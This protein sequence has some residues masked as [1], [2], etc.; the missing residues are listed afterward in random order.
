MLSSSNAIPCGA[1][2]DAATAFEKGQRE[3]E[4]L[5]EEVINARL[6]LQ[7][8]KAPGPN[9]GR[10]C[11]RCLRAGD[12]LVQW[13]DGIHLVIPIS[14]ED[15]NQLSLPHAVTKKSAVLQ[16]RQVYLITIKVHSFLDNIHAIFLFPFFIFPRK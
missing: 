12:L 10:F 3:Q 15:S 16:A 1:L 8:T 6:I 2:Q 14:E 7:S 13:K 11:F 9:F 4:F 5:V